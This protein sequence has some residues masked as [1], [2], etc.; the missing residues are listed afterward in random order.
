MKIVQNVLSLTQ[1]LDLLV[2][3]YN[4]NIQ[5]GILFVDEA[6]IFLNNPYTQ[7]KKKKILKIDRQVSPCG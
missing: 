1:I 2:C 3:R 5:L 6:L 7:D 4:K